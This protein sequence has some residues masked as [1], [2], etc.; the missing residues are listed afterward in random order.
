MK[1]KLLKIFILFVVFVTIISLSSCSFF[2]FGKKET[3]SEGKV[4][5]SNVD[6][7]FIAA[8]TVTDDSE[9]KM[10]NAKKPTNID[11]VKQYYLLISVDMTLIKK[12]DKRGTVT[13]KLEIDD[14]A[15]VSGHQYIASG[16]NVVETPITSSSGSSGINLSTTNKAPEDVDETISMLFVIL[17]STL[18]VGNTP[19]NVSF[20][21][22]GIGLKGKTDGFSKTIV[23]NKV[24]LNAPNISFDQTRLYLTWN[25]VANADY[26]KLFVDGSVASKDGKQVVYEVDGYTAVDATINWDI[27]SYVSGTHLI[28][29]QAFSNST[30]FNTSNYSNEISVTL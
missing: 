17:L 21:S 13:M 2:D 1:N 16:S 10:S 29:I 23:V 7:G 28:T 3:K 25:N 6:Y 15:F 24:T 18:K 4:E 27:S 9:I 26:Y 5:L 30:N 12:G 19:F 11:V 22:S 14:I 8:N 20:D